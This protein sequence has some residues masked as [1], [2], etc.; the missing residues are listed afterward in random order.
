MGE[1]KGNFSII[2]AISKT[3]RGIGFENSIPWARTPEGKKD[4]KWFSKITTGSFSETSVK[5]IVIMGRKTYE[6]IPPKF[7]PLPNRINYIVSRSRTLNK[8]EPFYFSSIDSALKS[9][10]EKQRKDGC[11]IFVIGGSEIYKETIVYPECQKLHITEVEGEYQC[12]RFFPTIPSNY[13][14]S[15]EIPEEGLRFKTY[16]NLF[17]PLSEEIQYL[18]LLD[19]ILTKGELKSNRTQTQT[20]GLFGR[21]LRFSLSNGTLPLITTKKMF[22]R[23][24]IE[25]LLFFLRGDHDNRKLQAKKVH[26]WDGNTTREYLDKYSKQQ[27]ET[28][29]LGLAYGVQWRAAGAK[30]ES[31]D[32]DY[33]GK[34]ID[35]L[36]NVIKTIK[37]DPGSRR[38][39]IN[40]WNVPQL[41]DMALPP[42]H[43]MY[44]FYVSTEN[45]ELS[46]MMTQR[47]AD[48]FLGLPF[49]IASTA[50]LTHIIAK[51]CNLNP[52]EIIINLGDVHIYEN[53]I[54]QVK[55]QLERVPYRF[56]TIEIKK[57]LSGVGDIESLQYEDFN[58]SGYKSH[59]R[60]KADMVV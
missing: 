36:A 16:Q 43:M 1:P 37:T 21:Q 19:E 29:D 18:D 17:D 30:L 32:T 25:E 39:I 13:S 38:I 11:D 28:N 51:S 55:T 46:C 8:E 49:N 47:S 24:V 23:G 34:G 53:H 31:I 48:T 9:A 5:N 57:E 2:V 58:I 42:C 20:I 26:I 44:Q 15:V 10:Y 7:R 6:S 40:S 3:N 4:L 14:L 33:R 52:G 60:I 50:I 59:P 22:V 54:T 27:I 56:P 12:D 41:D 45:N 35:Q